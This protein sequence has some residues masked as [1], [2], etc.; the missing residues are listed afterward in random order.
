VARAHL[1][2]DRNHVGY[3]S[4][5][6]NQISKILIATNNT[7]LN[8]LHEIDLEAALI[9]HKRT[10]TARIDTCNFSP[11]VFYVKALN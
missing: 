11:I 9:W 1:A 5:D 8:K 4:L 3:N 10:E 6:K 2:K 7:F